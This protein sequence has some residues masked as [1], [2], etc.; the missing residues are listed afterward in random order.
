VSARVPWPNPLTTGVEL[1][2]RSLHLVFHLLPCVAKDTHIPSTNLADS[3]SDAAQSFAHEE[4]THDESTEVHQALKSRGSPSFGMGDNYVPGGLDASPEDLGVQ[5]DVDPTGISMFASMIEYLLSQFTFSAEDVNITVIYP[6][7]SS[8]RFKVSRIRYGRPTSSLHESTRT[9]EISGVEIAH[10]DLRVSESP[11]SGVKSPSSVQYDPGATSRRIDPVAPATV[12]SLYSS[13]QTQ[14]DS[15]EPVNPSEP[16]GPEHPPRSVSPSDS[17]SSSLFQSALMTQG[18]EQESGGCESEVVDSQ[19]IGGND[20]AYR[21]SGRMVGNN[22]LSCA[23]GATE[24]EPY[25]QVVVSLATEPI[26]VFL[27]TSTPQA[28]PK[29]STQSSQ[30]TALDKPD[31]QQPN[32]EVSISVGVIACALTASQICAMLDV[33]SVVGSHSDRIAQPPASRGSS[34]VPPALSLLDQTS[35][36]IQIR[37][38]VLL[39]ESA[40][41]SLT[42]C[43]SGEARTVP[44]DAL[45]DFFAHPLVPPK[46]AHS[47]FRF[48]MDTIKADFSVS[49]TLE[50]LTGSPFPRHTPERSRVSRGVVGKTSSRLGFS[51]GDLS[52]C[53][54][55]VPDNSTATHE[56]GET[57]VLPIL[58]TDLFLSTQYHPEHRPLPVIGRQLDT[59]PESIRRVFQTLPEFE[60]LDWTSQVH[61]TSQAKLS[62][63]RVKPPPG[64]RR[65]HRKH[66]GSSPVSSPNPETVIGE[67]SVNQSQPAI[68][69]QI[70]LV[71]PRDPGTDST[72]GSTCSTSI[73]IVPIHIFVDMGSSKT[74]LEFL[75]ILST[76][77]NS[78]DMDLSSSR[79]RSSSPEGE[80]LGGA[81]GN[82]NSG[83]PTPVSSPLRRTLQPIHLQEL[84]EL[85]LSEDYLSKEPALGR[86]SPKPRSMHRHSQVRICFN[87][88]L[89]T[90][91]FEEKAPSHRNSLAEFDVNFT[92]IRIQLRC[93]SPSPLLQRSGAII[94]DI[95]GLKLAIGTRGIHDYQFSTKI[96]PTH[97]TPGSSDNH[98]VTAEWRALL[99]SC[100]SAG[101][102]IARCFCSIGPLSST[103]DD[104]ALPSL[105]HIHFLDDAPPGRRFTVI[106]LS[107]NSPSSQ[108]QNRNR[109]PT[110]VIEVDIPSMCLSLSKP[111][112]D[113]LQFWIDDVSRLIERTET[114]SGN[115]AHEGSSR[116]PS[117]VGSRFFSSSKQGSVEVSIDES[118]PDYNKSLTESI[119]KVTISEGENFS[120]STS[121]LLLCVASMRL[122]VHHQSEGA[123]PSVEPFDILLS[124]VDAL[125]ESKPEGKV[126]LALACIYLLTVLLRM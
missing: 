8:F 19:G 99:L 65:S 68:S 79:S 105:D 53:A 9:I 33:I 110:F 2:V 18:S 25:H 37:G 87:C 52:A 69:G 115:E 95:H 31:S 102:A 97:R 47:Y 3:I 63:W 24:G 126:R 100:S 78:S 34:S 42:S 40:P 15:N 119:V 16:P 29:A 7:H 59:S 44:H 27:T 13:P 56:S 114:Q 83:E 46:I 111:L 118:T 20:S 120:L 116:N 10:C 43:S 94:L 88:P 77:R 125:L 60:I 58:L 67:T 36:T 85:N 11:V 35:L 91:K 74:A 50:H 23:P 21:P 76:R 112:F 66:G 38:F 96:Q 49:T 104:G 80:T 92:M 106:K 22:R 1:S 113:S 98:A 124:D 55:C 26:V 4:I 89:P 121:Q 71:S 64:N 107:R 70:L 72:P 117:L 123:P 81:Y 108:R 45:D 54:F 84:D 90:A 61:R 39:L 14:I 62:F 41:T 73:S 122:L 57:F 12:S 93:P 17:M 51:V 86:L 103:V 101:A 5:S 28:L 32:L 30:T 75:E 82:N 109:L 48:V 6:G